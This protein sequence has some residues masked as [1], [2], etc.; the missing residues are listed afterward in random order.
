MNNKKAVA[1]LIF[2][3]GLFVALFAGMVAY[4][5]WHPF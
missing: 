3:G 1:P 4:K 5:I 2:Y